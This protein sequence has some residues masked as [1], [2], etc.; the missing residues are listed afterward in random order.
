[1]RDYQ[2]QVYSDTIF[3]Y[4]NKRFVGFSTFGKQ[5]IDSVADI[6]LTDNL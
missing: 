4:D 2:I 6:I 1:M 3:L 5:G